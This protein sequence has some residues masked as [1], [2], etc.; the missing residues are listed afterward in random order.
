MA[1]FG[2]VGVVN[3]I[4]DFAVFVGLVT[5][6][7]APIV[8][9]G[10]GFLVAN[11]QS[12]L[13]NSKVTFRQQGRAARVS[14]GGYLRFVAAHALSLAISTA[15]IALLADR[16]GVLQTKVLATVVT[17]LWNYTIS[18]LFVFKARGRQ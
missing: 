17:F 9:N 12:Y 10:A 11:A 14:L 4:V 16:I 15:M 7:A 18:V 2:G 1:R 5:A 8:A 6:G 3:T 13:L